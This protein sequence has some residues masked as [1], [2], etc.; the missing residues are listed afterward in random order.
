M[1]EKVNE[2]LSKKE[3]KEMDKLKKEK[4]RLEMQAMVLRIQERDKEQKDGKSK[5]VDSVAESHLNVDVNDSQVQ[6]L[7]P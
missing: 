4:D 3:R 7:I 2:N 6:E 1:K 5:V